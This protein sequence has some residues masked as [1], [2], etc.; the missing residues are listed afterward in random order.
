MD[1]ML[2]YPNIGTADSPAEVLDMI[3]EMAEC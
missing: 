1:E 3:Q 2:K